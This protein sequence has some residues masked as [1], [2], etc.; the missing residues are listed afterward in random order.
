MQ[1]ES[2]IHLVSRPEAQ[3]LRPQLRVVPRS[4]PRKR[5]VAALTAQDIVRETLV[6]A[7]EHRDVLAGG[8]ISKDHLLIDLVAS[9]ALA[10]IR[11]AGQ[12]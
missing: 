3:F 6:I 5:K 1:N 2:K 4:K 12:R 8:P 7:R 11:K 9:L 10:R